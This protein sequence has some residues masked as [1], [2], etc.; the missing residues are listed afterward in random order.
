MRTGEE[1]RQIA[2]SRARARVYPN[3]YEA[4]RASRHGKAISKREM[5]V[6]LPRGSYRVKIVKTLGGD[7][8]A[9]YSTAE[10]IKVH[11]WRPTIAQVDATREWMAM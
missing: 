6:V 7:P 1:K 4:A 8:H 10:G 9:V 11:D 2:E 3:W 5:T